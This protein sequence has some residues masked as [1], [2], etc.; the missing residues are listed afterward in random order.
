MVNSPTICQIVVSRALTPSRSANPQAT[1][2]QYMDDILIAAPLP[3]Q[4][5][6]LVKAV[7]EV[8]KA[9]GFEI[10]EAKIKR[11]PS[12]TFLG[13]K[14]NS[15][16]VSPPAIKIRHNIKTLHDAQQVVGS[17][18]CLRNIVL[19][20]PEVMSPLH[21]L[22]KGKHPWE[23]K[24]ISEEAARSLNYI[25]RQ[26]STAVLSRWNPRLPLYLYVHFT[27]EGGIGALAQGPPDSAKP[28]QWVV[29]GR[30]SRAFTP[31]VHWKPNYKGQKTRPEPS[32]FRTCKNILTVLE[33]DLIIVC[34][35]LRVPCPSSVLFHGRTLL[36]C[37]APVDSTT[38]HSGH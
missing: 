29:L 31:G 21:D 19:V 35:S 18:Q 13:V 30:L 9:N 2:I 26:L 6:S 4:V 5:D 33:A 34:S 16:Y 15:S 36:R 8:L 23:Q 37:E 12:V 32:G 38:N 24:T 3:S 14:T 1:V 20:P 10:A 22:L 27:K 28:V 17:L 11:G 25:E 7:S